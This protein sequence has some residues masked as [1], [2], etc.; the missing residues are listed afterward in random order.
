MFQSEN[1]KTGVVVEETG[2]KKRK[3][4][5]KNCTRKELNKPCLDNKE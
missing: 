5:K 4:D 1:I 2:K 3:R